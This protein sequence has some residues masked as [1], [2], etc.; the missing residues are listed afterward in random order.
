MLKPG[1]LLAFADSIQAQDG[2]ELARMLEAFPALFHEPF[3]G[4]Y[5][6]TDL[7]ALF[8]GAGLELAGRDQAF[9]TKALLFAKA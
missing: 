7:P 4:T 1:G 3:F 9:L 6:T 5:Q 8:G 2:P